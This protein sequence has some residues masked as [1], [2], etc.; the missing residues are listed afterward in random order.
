[1]T[2]GTTAMDNQRQVYVQ[3][4]VL[5]GGRNAINVP[6]WPCSKCGTANHGQRGLC[7]TVGCKGK[8]AKDVMAQ[9]ASQQKKWLL[10]KS[11]TPAAAPHTPPSRRSKPSTAPRG[12]GGGE[13]PRHRAN[14]RSASRQK[15]LKTKTA[16]R[17]QAAPRG[18]RWR[19]T[20]ADQASASV[21]RS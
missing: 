6:N 9:Q 20:S 13:S 10:E 12:T 18:R 14:S 8:P 21:C 16:T 2:D 11:L 1:M 7:F 17:Q 5:V 19:P 4:G 15:K 3:S